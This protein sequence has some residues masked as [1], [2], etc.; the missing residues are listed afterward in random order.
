MTMCAKALLGDPMP[1]PSINSNQT[2]AFDS[3]METLRNVVNVHSKYWKSLQ[4][5]KKLPDFENNDIQKLQAKMDELKIDN[6]KFC[7]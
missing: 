3:C 4:F 1:T 6:R 2:V 7:M 5:C